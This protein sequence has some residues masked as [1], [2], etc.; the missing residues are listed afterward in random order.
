MSTARRKNSDIEDVLLDEFQVKPAALGKALA[1]FFG[2]P[3]EP[4]K[5]DRVRPSD[6][7]KNLKREYV[8]SSQWVR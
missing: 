1:L 7:L 5:A 4:F 6:L 2:V 8:E 3:Y